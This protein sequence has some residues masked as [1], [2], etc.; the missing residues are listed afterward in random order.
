VLPDGKA[1]LFTVTAPPTQGRGTIDFDTAQ[2]AALNV[3]TGQRKTLI[4]GGAQAEYVAPSAGAG[5]SGFLVYATAGTLRA[6]R[7]DP[8]KLEVLSDSVP[9]VE[10]VLMK[11]SGAAEFSASHTGALVFL[12]GSAV[13]NLQRSLVWVTRQGLETPVKAPPRAYTGLHI[14]P[15][16]T[17]IAVASLD[18]Q[19][20][21]WIWDIAREILRRLTLDPAVDASPLWTPDGL[22]IIFGSDRDGGRMDL[23]RQASDTTGTVER[24]TTSRNLQIPLAISGD[25][26]QVLTLG[27]ATPGNMDLLL[28]RL[29]GSSPA[30]PLLQTSFRENNGAL[31]PDGR[32][33]AYDSD[34]SG[35]SE[36]HVRPFPNVDGGH[37][38]VSAA[39]G[40]KPTWARSGREL[41][42]LAPTNAM[43]TVAVQSTETFT[44]GA[45]TKLFDAPYWVRR[46]GRS[47]DVSPDGQKFLMIKE[48]PPSDGR[49][50]GPAHMV[51]VLNWLEELKARVPTN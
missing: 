2:V 30:R 11:Q 6:V 45:P 9:V 10:G 48:A 19:R 41:F 22:R 40:V 25:G 1:I 47:Y 24:L 36:I 26:T 49:A 28:Q 4:R 13:G 21:I 32:W 15:D 44:Y 14:S 35:Q 17:R 39:G 7:F 51:V 31:S 12:P 50:D 16:G 33:L 29:D 3:Q 27:A 46:G 23:Y 42:Y 18:Q 34:E 8:A 43:M 5:S 37:W 20:D 38:Q